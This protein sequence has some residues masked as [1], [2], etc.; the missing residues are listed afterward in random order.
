MIAF[1]GTIGDVK[2]HNS[3]L[4]DDVWVDV[5]IRVAGQAGVTAAMAMHRAKSKLVKLEYELDDAND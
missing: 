2:M 3:K 1:E 4:N 5:T